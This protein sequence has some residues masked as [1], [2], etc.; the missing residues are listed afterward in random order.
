M[1]LSDDMLDLLIQSGHKENIIKKMEEIIEHYREYCEGLIW[2]ARH[3]KEKQWLSEFGL[4]IAKI[5][6]NMIRLLDHTFKEIDNRQDVSYNRK[7]NHQIQKYLFKEGNLKAFLANGDMHFAARVLA[8]LEGV[9][10]LDP[11]LV[12]DLQT[13]I[14]GL[15]PKIKLYGEKH[16]SESQQV[17][18]SHYFYTTQKSLIAKQKELKHILEVEIPK[19]S[20]EIGFAIE[21]GDLSENA[22]Y[23]AGKERQ[24]SLQ[25]HVGRLK[26]EI[27][28]ARL[29]PEENRVAGK[30]GF[31]TVLT[32]DDIV[33]SKE[34][35]FTILGPW[36]SN[37]SEKTISYLSPFGRM[38]IGRSEGDSLDFVINDRNYKY[39][40]KSVKPLALS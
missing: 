9:E 26:D 31:G 1:Q 13:M 6:I 36:E 2:I 30:I 17:P 24:E 35:I 28:R 23:K 22:E 8:L 38:F 16:K 39:S 21:L 14:Q 25:I 12:C 19:N 29:F 11:T 40:V 27:E 34:E 18:S 32:L 10:K 20:K 5:I 7:L 4:D 33:E 15:F 37:P 3:A